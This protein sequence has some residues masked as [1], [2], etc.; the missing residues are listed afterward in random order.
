MESHLVAAPASAHIAGHSAQSTAELEAN[1]FQKAA[2][3]LAE[4]STHEYPIDEVKADGVTQSP[5]ASS[6]SVPLNS[7]D[8]PSLRNA[9]I[10]LVTLLSARKLSAKPTYNVDYFVEPNKELGLA[11]EPALPDLLAI[12]KALDVILGEQSGTVL[13]GIERPPEAR[14]DSSNFTPEADVGV[15]QAADTMLDNLPIDEAPPAIVSAGIPTAESVATCTVAPTVDAF[16]PA[17]FTLDAVSPDVVYAIPERGDITPPV[18]VNSSFDFH[19]QVVRRS[20]LDDAQKYVNRVDPPTLHKLFQAYYSTYR[21]MDAAQKRWYFYWRDQYRQGQALPTDLSYLFVYI[22]E[23]IHAVGFVRPEDA[24]RNLLRLWTHYGEAYPNLGRYLQSWALDMVAYYQLENDP[25][26]LVWTLS[27]AGVKSYD[28]DLLLTAHLARSSTGELPLPLIFAFSGF[29]PKSTKFSR[30]YADPSRIEDCC[31]N[32]IE[33][34]NT[35]YL[36]TTGLDIFGMCRLQE[37]VERR[38]QAFSGAVFEYQTRT[39]VVAEVYSFA[40]SAEIRNILESA[41][42]LSENLLRKQVGFSGARRDINLP[43]ELEARLRAVGGEDTKS[44]ATR[45]AARRVVTVDFARVSGLQIESQE[46]R[47]QLIS[48]SETAEMPIERAFAESS[49]LLANAPLEGAVDCALK[50]DDYIGMDIVPEVN[51]SPV[52]TDAMPGCR[53]PSDPTHRWTDFLSALTPLHVATLNKLVRGC[54]KS[55]FESFATAHFTMSEQLI[56]EVNEKAIDTVGDSVIDP[57]EEPIGIYEEHR[58]SLRLLLDQ[59]G[60]AA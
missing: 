47:A 3:D 35:Y 57:Y 18:P 8:N 7:R 23:C 44:L 17:I 20:F 1:G 46:I 50:A 2:F 54:S 13:N 36:D 26:E 41:L 27:Q 22:Y 49:T 39:V 4:E 24:L 48:D 6:L 40:G 42:K 19:A 56:E 45:P 34:V 38:H 11:E 59:I 53:A 55:E 37:K 14:T 25:L 21:D 58:E 33:A 9:R 60:E 32:A 28:Q 52:T 16:Q 15:A 10:A 30:E 12:Q 5:S 29:D 31:R 43:A 51:N